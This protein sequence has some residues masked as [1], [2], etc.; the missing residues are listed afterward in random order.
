MVDSVKSAYTYVTSM[1]DCL[2]T[3][4]TGLAGDTGATGRQGP[5]GTVGATGHTGQRGPRGP[6]GATGFS[7][8]SGATGA[9]ALYTI[10]YRLAVAF[11]W[12]EAGRHISQNIGCLPFFSCAKM[13]ECC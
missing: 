8:V 9:L 11:L 5:N 10:I 3:G 13:Q 7:G 2:L 6:T 4:S 12:R 1:V